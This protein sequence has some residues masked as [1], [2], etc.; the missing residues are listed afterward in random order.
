MNDSRLSIRNLG[1][2]FNSPVLQGVDLDVAQGEI[3][4]VVGENGAGKSTMINIL[5]GLLQPDTGEIFLDG[6]PHTPNSVTAG[7]NSG[8]SFA[9]QELSLIETLSVAENIALRQLP[10]NRNVINR[11]TLEKT[12][13]RL[14]D[15]VGLHEISPDVTVGT[16][17]LAK[18]QLIEIAKAIG[19]NC[20]VLLLDEPTASLT[21]DQADH[22]HSVISQLAANGTSVVYISHRLQDVIDITD[23]VTVL[24]DGAVVATSRSDQVTVDQLVSQMTGDV[25]PDR[26]E[27]QQRKES[28]LPVLTASNLS[29]ADLPNAFDLTCHSGEI[30]GV[31]GLAGAGKSELLQ[32]LFGL[33]SKTSGQVLHR[34]GDKESQIQ[35]ARQAVR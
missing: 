27:R 20:R 5:T 22:V 15:L 12:A 26:N 30:L 7:F 8:V 2:S 10:Q 24:R 14:L 21:A 32:A 13:R 6:E 33:T 11:T 29:T 3:L 18:R 35:S 23:R 28:L 4:G 19:T 1:K 31:A 16:L 9:A 25:M 34:S 17:S